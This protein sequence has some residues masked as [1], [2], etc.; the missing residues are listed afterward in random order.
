METGIFDIPAPLFGSIDAALA[1]FLPDSVRL[2]FWGIAAGAGSMGLYWLTSP[3]KK[4][5]QAKIDSV[6]ARK[7]LSAYEGDFDGIFPLMVRSLSTSIRHF[8][9]ALGPALLGALPVIFLMVW[10][11]GSYGYRMPEAGTDVTVTT[12]GRSATLAWTDGTQTETE[13]SW[14]VSWPAAGETLS[15]TDT[16]G[17]VLLSLPLSHPVPV[18][19][20][21]VWWNILFANPLGSLPDDAPAEAVEIGLEAKLFMPFGPGW[22]RGWEAP[23]ILVVLVA[24]VAIKIMFRIR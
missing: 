15:L 19:H 23:F 2:I 13:N 1:G 7:A 4:L 10:M 14:T 8:G 18:R 6:A 12:I 20:K 16:A 3:Q 11:A 17:D 22:M 5:E 9:L 24:S 21:H